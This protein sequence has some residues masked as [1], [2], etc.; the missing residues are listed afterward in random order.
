MRNATV[1]LLMLGLAWFAVEL[2]EPGLRCLYFCQP[3]S[4]FDGARRGASIL[5]IG[6]LSG[7]WGAFYAALM[8]KHSIYIPLL[9]ALLASA[10]L[11]A[12]LTPSPRV[13]GV[14][15]GVAATG[16][17]LVRWDLLGFGLAG[18]ASSGHGEGRD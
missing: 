2:F 8:R 16:F 14:I 11:L 18:S 4:T 6:F 9:S 7:A 10:A 3:E 17:S 15:G 12:L 1:V 13:F 5:V